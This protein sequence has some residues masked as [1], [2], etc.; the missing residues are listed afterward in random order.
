MTHNK[1]IRFE[2]FIIPSLTTKVYRKKNKVFLKK[3]YSILTTLVEKHNTSTQTLLPYFILI[4]PHQTILRRS[5]KSANSQHIATKKRLP[6][7]QPL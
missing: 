4:N 5:I 2:N 3:P 7:G 6:L 1:V